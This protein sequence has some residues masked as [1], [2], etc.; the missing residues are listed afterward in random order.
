M[1]TR[2]VIVFCAIALS[3]GIICPGL[4]TVMAMEATPNQMECCGAN[5]HTKHGI[6]EDLCTSLCGSQHEVV[7]AVPDFNP[8]FNLVVVAV[9]GWPEHVLHFENGYKF[10]YLESH[11]P[12]GHLVFL[13]TIRIQC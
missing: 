2:L 3:I 13:R 12:P 4:C 6:N 5:Q 1:K 7:S 10:Q 8:Q 9:F 11:H